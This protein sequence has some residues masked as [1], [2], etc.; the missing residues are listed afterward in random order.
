MRGIVFGLSVLVCLVQPAHAAWVWVYDGNKHVV[1]PPETGQ[2]PW[3]SYP[4]TN[5]DGRPDPIVTK[6]A[7]RVQNEKGESV[8]RVSAGQT[9]TLAAVPELGGLEEEP[10]T[11]RFHLAGPK[12]EVAVEP[13]AEIKQTVPLGTAP[14]VYRAQYAIPAD[15]TGT[16]EASVEVTVGSVSLPAEMAPKVQF[17]AVAPHEAPT[18]QMARAVRKGLSD[19]GGKISKFTG[20]VAAGARDV[21][22]V[23]RNAVSPGVLEE[24]QERQTAGMVKDATHA[25]GAQLPDR[26]TLSGERAAA[27][28]SVK[29]PIQSVLVVPAGKAEADIEGGRPLGWVAFQGLRPAGQPWEGRI[30]PAEGRP[31]VLYR[32]VLKAEP[33]A[34][35][36]QVRLLAADGS[37]VAELP[38][39]LKW[40]KRLPWPGTCL[41]HAVKHPVE[42]N[43]GQGSVAVTAIAAVAEG[44]V[45]AEFT[46]PIRT[47]ERP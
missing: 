11:V 35:Q 26:D 29:P 5:G 28:H 22:D 9:V 23:G 10:L 47:S 13:A 43:E 36:G 41:V 17:Q 27:V 6:V 44:A 7:L 42:A 38:A 34:A 14:A 18:K 15:Q 32:L 45:R 24:V 20:R 30:V 1:L 4:D 33:N 12:G 39:T 31:F 19:T 37:S 21:F 2:P 46:L 8:A 16:Y 3:A 40:E 25:A